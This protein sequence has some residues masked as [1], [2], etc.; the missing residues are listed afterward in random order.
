M[1]KINRTAKPLSLQQH[2]PQW[3]QEL[4]QEV[5]GKGTYAA[6]A[7]VYKNKYRKSDVQQALEDMYFEKCCYCEQTIGAESYEHIE[8]LR[9]KSNVHFHHLAFDWH[10]LHWCCQRCNM[11]KSAQWDAVNPI[12]DP[13]ID[14]PQQHIT[15]NLITAQLQAQSQRGQ[16]TIDHTQLNRTKLVKAR[17]RTLQKLQALELCV[18]QTST[19]Q[20]D[21]QLINLLDQYVEQEEEFSA[22]IAQYIEKIRSSLTP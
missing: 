6:V 8:H 15:L 22:I 7:E 16:T 11:A 17:K 19:K 14:E 21:L 20:D 10:N 12:L 2:A 1:K 4:L 3:T 18:K 5:Q 13:T 9:P